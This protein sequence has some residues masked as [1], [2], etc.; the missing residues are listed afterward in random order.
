MTTAGI[1]VAVLLSVAILATVFVCIWKFCGPVKR[2]RE[3]REYEK[4]QERTYRPALDGAMAGKAGEKGLGLSNI[5]QE[6][7]LSFFALAKPK[8]HGIK[9]KTIGSG[10]RQGLGGIGKSPLISETAPTVSSRTEKGLPKLPPG[11]GP[12]QAALS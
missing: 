5:E 6:R 4:M 11:Q 10:P 12:R 1:A 8:P 3:K 7:P 2:W 9:R